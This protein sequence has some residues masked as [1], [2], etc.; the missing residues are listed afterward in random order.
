MEQDLAKY[1]TKSRRKVLPQLR[2]VPSEWTTLVA[3]RWK[4]P[5]VRYFFLSGR[6]LR[7][8]DRGRIASALLDAKGLKLGEARSAVHGASFETGRL[9]PPQSGP[10]WVG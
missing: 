3:H 10:E 2:D 8:I 7:Q 5:S 6:L 1:N 4:N 9:Q